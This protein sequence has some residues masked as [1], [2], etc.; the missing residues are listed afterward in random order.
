MLFSA[1]AILAKLIYQYPVDA[2]TLMALRMMFSFPVFLLIALRSQWRARAEPWPRDVYWRIVLI[3]F[4]GYYLSS[5]LDFWG[6]AYIPAALERLILFLGPT[7]V[8]L[9]G[10]LF[11]GKRIQSR[12]WRA[13]AWCYLGIV[14]V[15]AEQFSLAGSSVGFGSLLVF[16]AMICYSLYLLLSGE[17]VQT[18]GTL[19]LVALAMCVSTVLTMAHFLILKSPGQLLQP[20]P[21]IM[22]SIINAVFCTIIPVLLTM[23]AVARIG[24]ARTSQLSAVGPVSLLFLAHWLLDEPITLLQCAGTAVV[25]YGVYVLTRPSQPMGQ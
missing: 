15:F 9:L 2:I 13:M 10:A 4:L 25:L 1:K 11:F 6:L 21:V 22:L 19:R 16:L 20:S 5:F 24:A 12:Q 3:G 7:A 14:L 8:L 23:M 18:F 17:L